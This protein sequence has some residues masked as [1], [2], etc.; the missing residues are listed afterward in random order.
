MD[1]P[2]VVARQR[3]GGWDLSARRRRQCCRAGA[4]LWPAVCPCRPPELF[5]LARFWSYRTAM[6]CHGARREIVQRD[7]G[8]HARGVR[9]AV[10]LVATVPASHVMRC[11]FGHRPPHGA[12]A[13]LYSVA[14]VPFR[15]ASCASNAAESLTL[16]WITAAARTVTAR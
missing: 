11:R 2:Q 7:D 12:P 5:C 1:Q 10:H 8:S 14:V 6:A 15:R 13:T 9:D 3:R 4:R 16:R